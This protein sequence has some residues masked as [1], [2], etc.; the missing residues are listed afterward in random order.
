[1]ARH[2]DQGMH[3]PSRDAE[4]LRT[5]K[6]VMTAGATLTLTDVITINQQLSSVAQVRI[7]RRRKPSKPKGPPQ[8]TGT[9]F[10]EIGNK[11]LARVKVKV[12]KGVA[13]AKAKVKLNAAGTQTIFA[14][15]EPDAAA[16]RSGFTPT[17]A[18]STVT[19]NPAARNHGGK[20]KA[21]EFAAAR[22][23]NPNARHRSR[24]SDFGS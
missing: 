24:D 23:T 7:D 4:V 22:R 21:T 12:L 14:V 16:E 1:M 18:S 6:S 9:V 20:P 19:V 11:V 8:P 15:Y 5:N 3:L 10:F 17:F 2:V 13:Q